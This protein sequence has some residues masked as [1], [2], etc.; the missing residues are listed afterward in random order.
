MRR[1]NIMAF[2]AV[3]LW[4]L[5]VAGTPA[6]AQLNAGPPSAGPLPVVEELYNPDEVVLKQ[7]R[8]R[9]FFEH[10]A[11][12]TGVATAGLF[13]LIPGKVELVSLLSTF[14]F[15]EGS[16]NSSVARFVTLSDPDQL[17]SL[18]LTFSKQVLRDGQWRQLKVHPHNDFASL[19]EFDLAKRRE[20]GQLRLKV[21]PALPTNTPDDLIFMLGE[22]FPDDPE[23]SC[24]IGAGVFAI[25]KS[26]FQVVFRDRR[27]TLPFAVEQ[28]VHQDERRVDLIFSTPTC[29]LTIGVTKKA[30]GGKDKDW[31][32]LVPL[33]NGIDALPPSAG[34]ATESTPRNP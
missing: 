2:V 32:Y 27:A 11:S 9:A 30:R 1:L 20:N 29:R 22:K 19:V 34:P 10:S 24:L 15:T 18:S 4:G 17:C 21:D 13:R 3:A 23:A 28:Q 25:T 12:C 16:P 8:L 26:G 6:G 31:V 14:I 5:T 33:D 7:T